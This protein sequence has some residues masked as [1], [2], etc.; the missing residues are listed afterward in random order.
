MIVGL[1][2]HYNSRTPKGS[3]IK[4]ERTADLLFL[5]TPRNWGDMLCPDY[6]HE[7]SWFNSRTPRGVR[8]E[9]LM[10]LCMKLLFKFTHSVRS[11]TAEADLKSA[12]YDILIHAL[13]MECDP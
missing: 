4:R 12:R 10:P 7:V 2:T 8:R 9:L 1:R 6:E 13:R 3:A 11:A 5:F